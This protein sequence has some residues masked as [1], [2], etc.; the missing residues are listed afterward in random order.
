MDRLQSRFTTA[1]ISS[2]KTL[3]FK[4]PVSALLELKQPRIAIES[5]AALKMALRLARKL[6]A[7]SIKVKVIAHPQMIADGRN[8]SKNALEMHILIMLDKE[9]LSRER[10]ALISGEITSITLVVP[11][12]EP[13]Y[14]TTSLSVRTSSSAILGGPQAHQALLYSQSLK[15]PVRTQSLAT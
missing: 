6:V 3:L 2:S 11:V 12:S 1:R 4:D 15:E 10:L 14:L 13:T 7:S 9:L 8:R 5:L